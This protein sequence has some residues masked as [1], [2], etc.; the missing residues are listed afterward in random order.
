MW[1]KVDRIV[2][3]LKSS[4]KGNSSKAD[5]EIAQDLKSLRV[6]SDDNFPDVSGGSNKTWT[7]FEEVEFLGLLLLSDFHGGNS[8]G[9]VCPITS[10]FVSDDVFLMDAILSLKNLLRL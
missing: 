4:S 3:T 10:A 6:F 1:R 2:E 5:N 9:E 8:E 7:T